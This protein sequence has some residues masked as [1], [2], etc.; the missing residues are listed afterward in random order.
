MKSKS[1]AGVSSHK[2]THGNGNGGDAISELPKPVTRVFST[3]SSSTLTETEIED[4]EGYSIT[5]PG[6]EDKEAVNT[7]S[8]ETEYEEM[9]LEESGTEEFGEDNF[10][11]DAFF[12]SY[13]ELQSK[14][15][16]EVIIGT[17]NR[18]RIVQQPPIPGGPFVHCV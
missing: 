5:R 6:D 10:A 2:E 3:E 14:S 17:D 1:F 12:A 9:F 18:V 13:P 11:M 16:A 15:I 8:T 4:V 7:P